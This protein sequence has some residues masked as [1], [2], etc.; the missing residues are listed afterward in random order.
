MRERNGPGE[1]KTERRSPMITSGVAT[2]SAARNSI[3]VVIT[4]PPS[5]PAS[6][7][8]KI[9]FILL[10]MAIDLTRRAP[11]GNQIAK[12]RSSAARY[13]GRFGSLHHRG[14]HLFHAGVIK[15]AL[16][17]P[18]VIA[19]RTCQVHA[20]DRFKPAIRADASRIRGPEHA[21]HGFAE[22][23]REMHR[24]G[25]IRHANLGALN[26]RSQFCGGCLAGKIKCARCGRFYLP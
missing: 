22:R 19:R 11:E 20:Y 5:N 6:N 10:T 9:V 26:E 24:A 14:C 18:A 7:P 23:H 4:I 12:R 1:M 3:T 13:S 21:D 8:A 15:W 17:E 16:A 2:P 25:I